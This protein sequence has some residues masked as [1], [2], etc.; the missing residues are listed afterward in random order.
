MYGVLLFAS[1][2]LQQGATCYMNSLLQSLYHIPEFRRCTFTMQTEDVVDVQKSIPLALQRLF[3]RMQFGDQSVSTTELTK[4]FGYVIV[5]PLLVP[6]V[7]LKMGRK[8]RI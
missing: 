6:D 4:S 5:L 7:C 8:G 1:N 2:Y 3:Y